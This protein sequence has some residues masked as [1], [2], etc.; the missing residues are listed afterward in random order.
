MKNDNYVTLVLL[1]ILLLSGCKSLYLNS[2]EMKEIDLAETMMHGLRR[3]SMGF[4]AESQRINR[5]KA[6]NR[7]NYFRETQGR[8]PINFDSDCNSRAQRLAKFFHRNGRTSHQPNSNWKGFNSEILNDS[9]ISLMRKFD[10]QDYHNKGIRPIDGFISDYGKS[11]KALGHRRWITYSGLSSMGYG[12]TN[13]Y[14]VLLICDCG[15][16]EDDFASYP[17]ADYQLPMNLA[18]EK[19]SFSLP[20]EVSF[21][22]AEV[23]M[24]IE[25]ISFRTKVISKNERGLGDNTVVWTVKELYHNN[26]IKNEYCDKPITIHVSNVI[27]ND[28]IVD[29]EYTFSI[30]SPKQS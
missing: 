9:K 21:Q 23:N 30:G 29:F 15:N 11:N 25:D 19:W 5:V 7:I 20:G 13:K 28:S 8:S 17:P 27:K 24:F 10:S 14:E 16:F 26:I 4:K 2:D 12:A 18:F 3:R 1:F 22:N 6:L